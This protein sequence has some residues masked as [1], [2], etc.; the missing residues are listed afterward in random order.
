MLPSTLKTHPRFGPNAQ[1]PRGQVLTHSSAAAAAAAAAAAGSRAKQPVTVTRY[2]PLASEQQEGQ[3][4]QPQNDPPGL[5]GGSYRPGSSTSSSSAPRYQQVRTPLG[6]REEGGQQQQQQQ[7]QQQVMLAQPP[8]FLYSSDNTAASLQAMTMQQPPQAP[9]GLQYIAVPAGMSVQVTL[10]PQAAP[11]A[12]QATTYVLQAPP[13]QQVV[14]LP[15]APQGGSFLYTGGTSLVPQV[16]R[17][18]RVLGLPGW[19]CE[20]SRRRHD[21]ASQ[22][23]VS[24]YGPA[25]FLCS[26]GVAHRGDAACSRR[27]STC[28]TSFSLLL[29]FL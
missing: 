27:V 24:P 4:Q 19:F 22:P 11:Q 7:P 10:Q 25:Y 14:T 2:M 15:A 9:P 20:H 6:G 18:A 13:T 1:A 23:R 26:D 21:C 29:L 8:S 5:G 12:A 3:A 17:W 28:N 16:G